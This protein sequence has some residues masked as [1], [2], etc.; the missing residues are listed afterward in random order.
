MHANPSRKAYEILEAIGPKNTGILIPGR[1]FDSL[2]TRH[3]RGGGWYDRFLFSVPSTWSR[4]GFCYESQLSMT[5]LTR[6]E[7]DQPVDYICAVDDMTSQVRII[8]TQARKI[9]A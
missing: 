7:W 3:G 5:P 4:I 6:M 8:D 9:G 2:G 1:A